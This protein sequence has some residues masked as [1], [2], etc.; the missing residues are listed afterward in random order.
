MHNTPPLTMFNEY[1]LNSS[2]VHSFF[3]KFV[4]Q[5][6]NQAAKHNHHLHK[7]VFFDVS[8]VLFL[9]RST[10]HAII[11]SHFNVG[12]SIWYTICTMLCIRF[13]DLFILCK[14]NRKDMEQGLSSLS[15]GEAGVELS[16]TILFFVSELVY[17]D[18]SQ[19]FFFF[20]LRWA[21]RQNHLCVSVMV[22]IYIYMIYSRSPLNHFKTN[23]KI[24]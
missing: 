7:L 6:H 3:F 5:H 9:R 1:N 16:I 12:R 14:W 2:R 15:S 11:H 10:C 19:I 8:F 23:D 22:T 17:Y 13:P 24:E 4:Y 21:I 20:F 18:G